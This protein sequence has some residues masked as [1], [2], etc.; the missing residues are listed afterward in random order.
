MVQTI[1]FLPGFTLLD[2]G[3]VRQFLITGEDKALLIDTGFPDSQIRQTVQTVT[4]KPVQVLMT[5]GDGDH[6]GGLADFGEC[7]IHKGDWGQIQGEITLH[8]LQEGDMFSCGGF[9]WEVVEIPGHTYGSVAF[10]ERNRQLL[11]PGD[12]VQKDG[13]IF[14]F[15]QNRNIKLYLQSLEKLLHMAQQVKQILPCHHDC[16]IGP[17][18]I[19]KNLEDAQAMAAGKLPGEKH[20]QMPCWVYQGKWTSFLGESPETYGA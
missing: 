17:E 9:D 4:D 14:L 18:W 10:L 3:R 19:E 15:G 1:P 6:T 5:H 13:P 8:P 7:W 20:S 11:L 12:S 2:D 16:P